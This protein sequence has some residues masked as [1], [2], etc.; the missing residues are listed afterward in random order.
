MNATQITLLCICG[1]VFRIITIIAD[2]CQCFEPYF[3]RKNRTFFIYFKNRVS[4]YVKI[5]PKR[6]FRRHTIG[7]N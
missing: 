4:E 6:V 2:N 3:Y 1:A 7:G 5:E